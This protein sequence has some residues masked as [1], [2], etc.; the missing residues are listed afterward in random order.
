MGRAYVIP[1]AGH[2]LT[3]DDVLSHCAARLAKFKIPATAVIAEA[4]PRTASGKV[5]KHVLR[6]QALKELG[7]D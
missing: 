6:A 7:L 3:P 4:I 2:V 1:A 5:Q